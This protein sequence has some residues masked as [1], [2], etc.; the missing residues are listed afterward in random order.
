MI[1]IL[2]NSFT[3]IGNEL[4]FESYSFEGLPLIF[5]SLFNVI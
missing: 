2:I 5:K 4:N 1:F 3:K